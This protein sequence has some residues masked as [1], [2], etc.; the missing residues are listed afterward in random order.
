[1]K[2]ILLFA[3]FLIGGMASAQVVSIPDANFKSRLISL[4]ATPTASDSYAKDSDGQFITVDANNDGQIDQAEALQ[5]YE[6]KVN[7]SSIA[8]LVG[9]EYFTNLTMLECSGNQLT[10][11]DVTALSN[12]QVLNCRVNHL[13][14]LNVSGL[15]NL[16]SIRFEFNPLTSF[17]PVGLSSLTYLHGRMCDLVSLNLSLFPALS[18]LEVNDNNLTSLDVSV[19]P[20]LKMLYC[21]NNQISDLNISGVSLTNL[22]CS[23]NPLP[24]IDVSGLT[25]LTYLGVNNT[26]ATNLNL[27]GCTALSVLRCSNNPLPSINTEDL[28]GLLEIH[29]NNTLITEL[30]LTHSPGLEWF[31]AGGNP[32]LRS[33]NIHNGSLIEHPFEC[34]LENNPELLMICLDEGEEELMLQYFEGNQLVPPYMSATCEYVPGQ[35]YNSISGKVRL[36]LNGNGCTDADSTPD[37][38]QVKIFDGV[39]EKIKFTNK[40]GEY[41][42]LVGPGTYTVSA[43]YAGTLFEG[44]P[45]TASA[46]FTGMNNE[47]F[48]QDFCVTPVGE[49]ADVSVIISAPL[50]MPGFD[51]YYHIYYRNNGNTIANG[52][53]TFAYDT[54]LQDYITAQPVEATS[55]GGVLTWGYSNLLPLEYGSIWVKLHIN[56]PTDVPAVNIDDVLTY[57]AEIGM[58]G[59]DVN[60]DNNT[61]VVENTVIGSFD[62]NNI[63]C[64]EGE[65]ESVEKIG[66]YLNYVI[67]FENTGNAAATFV[68]VTQEVDADKF[69]ISSFEVLGSSHNVDVTRTGNR[70]IYKF[71]NINL[72]AAGQGYV[73]FKVK[74]LQTLE[75]GDQ[76]MNKADIVFDYN[77]AIATNEAITVFETIMGVGD[78]TVDSSVKVYPNPARDILTIA[79]QQQ[80]NGVEIYDIHGRLLQTAIVNESTARL[81]ISNRS[82]GIYFLK[83]TTEKGI[84]VEKL[85]KE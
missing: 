44:M 17:A 77:F 26:N 64:L 12:I 84:K 15:S 51:A 34:Y 25:A 62:P 27:S 79:S 48:V 8:S 69:D 57:T 5:V 74:T 49:V 39:S 65:K 54:A 81:D 11:L 55:I 4:S 82:A 41:F 45:A 59:N 22:D 30:D 33:I 61:S 18:F 14:T 13:T 35:I 2:K 20:N 46:T 6:L 32:L 85:V 47:S 24:G 29:C 31:V 52:T 10:S 40:E 7:Y 78:V 66:E 9:I 1:M 72:D 60:L 73:I 58:Q 53:V 75:E 63:I 19:I 42:A 76:V 71:D 28:T 70:I 50:I 83:I 23:N 68:T 67:N 21:H 36:D 37:Y 3:L 43:P 80:I 16:N 56:A 38:Y